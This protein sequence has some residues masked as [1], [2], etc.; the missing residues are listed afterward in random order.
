[1]A[2]AFRIISSQSNGGAAA[3]DE[4]E[5]IAHRLIQRRKRG[6]SSRTT[7]PIFEDLL[8]A[9]RLRI[10]RLVR[11]YSLSD[12]REDAEQAA[13]IGVHRALATYD[14]AK[15]AF[16]T[17]VTW[18]IR[19]ELQS[20]RHRVRLDQRRSAIS[21]GITT[22]SLDGHAPH[23]EGAQVYEIA[24]ESAL[25]H[26]E[27]AASDAMVET[28]LDKLLDQLEAP[29]HER[30]I[31][32]EH[33]FGQRRAAPKTNRAIAEQ[34]RQIVRRTMRNCAKVIER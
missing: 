20:L 13:A 10:A 1:M 12:C 4:I 25:G 29:P 23:S 26:I 22:V 34:R 3:S 17:H 24:D 9:L 6:A 28:M 33:V 21:A 27:R 7:D 5:A 14:P 15:A 31:V 19:G 16:V 2:R 8:H 11:Q 30:A 32:R 18:Q